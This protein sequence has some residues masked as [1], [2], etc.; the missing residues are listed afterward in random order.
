VWAAALVYHVKAFKTFL[1]FPANSM[2]RSPKTR[3]GFTLVE[4][5]VVIAIIGILVAMLLPAVQSA[6]EAARRTQCRNNLK[7][8]ALAVLNYEA[9]NGAFPPSATWPASAS[10][11]QANNPTLG[12][13]W[14]VA[15]LPQLEQQN[16]Y[17]K[18]NFAQPMQHADNLLARSTKLQVMMCP[19]DSYNRQPFNGTSNSMTNQ[20]GDNWA[21]G[22]YGGNG[23]LAYHAWDFGS[24][25][26]ACGIQMN[27]AKT[28]KGW[29]DSR[30]RGVMGANASVTQQAIK[31]GTTNTIML[32][33]L[34][35]GVTS[36]DCR[37]TWAMPGGG[38]SSLWAHGYCGDDYGPN[39]SQSLLAD[40]TVGCTQIQAAV[41]G[42][43]ALAKMGMSCSH[44]N[45]GNI[46]QTA[47]SMH[48]GGVHVA[49][50]DGSVQWVGDFI[51]V[52]VN[53]VN[54]PSVWDR[55]MLSA[56]GQ[57]IPAGAF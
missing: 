24:A 45:W 2:R 11:H 3:G 37:G 25:N 7:Q 57:I 1:Y 36:F 15:I 46:Q 49:L 10:I 31:D 52:T 23:G 18:I 38:P 48:P 20:M 8:L 6:R 19:T 22:N 47:R 54:N 4:L 9:A 27:G 5:L 12:Y 56:D 33:E 34:R 16:V 42:D 13:S 35:S 40:D 32:A 39:N 53:N 17:D 51:E 30:L 29:T 26:T 21:R 41:G 55:L 44:G 14:V 28:D 50:C 43:A